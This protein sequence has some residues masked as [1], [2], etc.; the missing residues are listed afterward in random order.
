[1]SSGGIITQLS[2]EHARVGASAEAKQLPRHPDPE[3]SEGEGSEFEILRLRLRMT[4]RGT[5]NHIPLLVTLTLSGAKGKGLCHP[6]RSEGS[7][8]FGSE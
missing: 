2:C 7:F 4:S 6:E 1:M 8:A 3:R 5:W